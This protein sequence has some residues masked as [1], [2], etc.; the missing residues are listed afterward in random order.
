[1]ISAAAASAEAP[2]ESAESDEAEDSLRKLNS[3]PDPK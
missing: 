2:G 3:L 1:L